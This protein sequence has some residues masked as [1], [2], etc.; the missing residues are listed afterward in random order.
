MGGA[1]GVGSGEQLVRVS[2]C[3]GG[4]GCDPTVRPPSHLPPL[5][6]NFLPPRSPPPSPPPFKTAGTSIQQ[7]FASLEPTLPTME[8]PNRWAAFSPHLSA[9]RRDLN[10]LFYHV[11]P[12]F[13]HPNPYQLPGHETVCVVRHPA[14]RLLSEFAYIYMLMD[15]GLAEHRR[16]KNFLKDVIYTVRAG[17]TG[18]QCH[19]LPQYLYVWGDDEERTCDH[20]IRFEELDRAF[21]SL[22][23]KAGYVP[24]LVTFPRGTVEDADARLVRR[25]AHPAPYIEGSTASLLVHAVPGHKKMVGWGA[26][27]GCKARLLPPL[28]PPPPPPSS[29]RTLVTGPGTGEWCRIS[30]SPTFPNPCATRS[31]TCTTRITAGEEGSPTRP[32]RTTN[33]P[34]PPSL[35][36]TLRFGYKP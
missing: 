17:E 15:W 10:C 3:V 26:A 32:P 19:Y 27:E 13:L 2:V 9:V 35:R 5:H 28:P 6:P 33:Y 8:A 14:M 12:R 11:P 34:R 21:N 20:I 25:R 23:R 29:C 31:T 24:G 1:K 22:V 30:P 4:G 16:F 36:R 7:Y 18:P